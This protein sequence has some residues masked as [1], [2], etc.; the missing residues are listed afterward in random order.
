M[1][2]KEFKEFIEKLMADAKENKKSE[3]HIENAFLSIE[4]DKKGTLWRNVFQELKKA[5]TKKQ[6]NEF[7]GLFKQD[8]IKAINKRAVDQLKTKFRDQVDLTGTKTWEE[9]RAKIIK[10]IPAEEFDRDYPLK[11]YVIVSDFTNNVDK[12]L[13]YLAKNLS[14]ESRKKI[15]ETS[16]TFLPLIDRKDEEI[17]V[18]TYRNELPELRNGAK[19]N[20]K[21]DQ[22][23]KALDYLGT[24]RSVEK[25]NNYANALDDKRT[26]I[27]SG[28][29]HQTQDI[30]KKERE[31]FYADN[32]MFDMN[33][34][35]LLSYKS[36]PGRD[37][38]HVTT[39]NEPQLL[40]KLEDSDFKFSKETKETL[41]NIYKKMDEFGYIEGKMVGE[42]GTKVYG[43]SK[44]SDINDKLEEAINAKN[45]D[46][47]VKYANEHKQET[48]HLK[49]ILGM[50]DKG[51]PVKDRDNLAYP[52]N[53]DVARNGAFDLEFRKNIGGSSQLSGLFSTFNYL[54]AN[55]IS[56]EEYLENPRKCIEVGM[57]KL[58]KEELDLDSS[59]EGK[60][61]GQTIFQLGKTIVGHGVRD[62]LITYPRLIEATARFEKDKK[63]RE[64]NYYVEK[65]F[66]D[67]TYKKFDSLNTVLVDMHSKDKELFKNILITDGTMKPS[68]LLT[69]ATY[70]TKTMQIV[71]PAKFDRSEYIAKNEIDFKDFKNK[72]DKAM[73]DYFAEYKNANSDKNTQEFSRSEFASV[74]HQLAAEVCMQ[75]RHYKG[76]PDYEQVMN[77]VKNPKEYVNNLTSTKPEISFKI[78]ADSFDDLS[79]ID[80]HVERYIKDH[81]NFGNNI[82]TEDK[83]FNRTLLQAAKNYNTAVKKH[84]TPQANEIKSK[85]YDD[86]RKNKE[87]LDKQ[88]R[89][90]KITE[91]YYKARKEQLD[92][93]KIIDAVKTNGKLPDVP[94]MFVADNFPSKKD[95]IKSTGLEQLTKDEE[96]VLYDQAKKE[97]WNWKER[98]F[99]KKILWR[100]ENYWWY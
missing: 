49:E 87:N 15:F 32:N 1:G 34:E 61:T 86:V 36:V 17:T 52:G 10:K 6:E 30:Q 27:E 89:E 73:L 12:A 76:D 88:F 43:Y 11:K 18:Q 29:L 9:A 39:I 85:L 56:L 55:N 94:K 71:E 65:D 8:D 47:I 41:R 69:T 62:I 22:I 44:L 13:P 2:E 90:G 99:N 37:H 53:V 14:E 59:T 81:K 57:K 77:F 100:K 5:L 31:K 51:M 91:S 60:T 78:N 72:M 35:E 75:K 26:T 82:I 25:E 33:D 54:K 67:T 70:N 21:K 79:A 84:R 92:V 93:E 68:Q 38:T 45:Y 28:I 3:N 19:N 98:L 48:E 7:I 63:T 80:R 40:K 96:N 4:N 24:L 83:N 16:K 64:A 23:N 50:I 42:E 97:G 74:V 46:D 95:Y 20:P 66:I 58:E